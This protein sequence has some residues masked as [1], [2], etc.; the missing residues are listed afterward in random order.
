VVVGRVHFTSGTIADF[1]LN[2]L[3][4][5]YLRYYDILDGNS[6]NRVHFNLSNKMYIDEIKYF[7]DCVSSNRKCMNS[8]KE[9]DYL[10]KLLLK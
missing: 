5:E 3:S 4:T 10:L 1:T 2:Y 8:F 6:L 9:A 7:V